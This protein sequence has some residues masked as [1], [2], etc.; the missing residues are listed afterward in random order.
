MEKFVDVILPLPL[1]A[2][3]TYSLPEDIA[4][5]VQIG[6]RV[7]VPFGR[8]K[9][10]TAIVQNIHYSAPAGYEVKEVSALLDAHPILLPEQFRFWDWLAD[11]YLCTRGDVY[12]AALPSGL[13]LESE[14]I[15]EY[16]P[17]FESDVQLP[18]KEQKILDL[19]AAE[20]EQCITKLEKESGIRNILSVIKSL[21]D[22]EAVFV[23]EELKRTYK[24][25]TETRVRLTEAAGNEHR[26]HFFFDELQR[27]A[28]KQLDLLMKYIE[29]SA[30][31]G[32]TPKEVT[33][34]ELLQRT[35]AT[36]AVFNGLV[37]RGVF[38]VYQQEI[39]R[40]NAA[41]ARTTLPLNPLNGHQQRAYCGK[42]PDKECLFAAWSHV[43]RKNGD[44][45]SSDRKSYPAREAGAVSV[46]G[47]SPDH[48]DYRKAATG[49][50]FA[51]GHLSLQVSG[52]RTGGNLAETAFGQWI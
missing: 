10:Y 37:E 24:P 15:V 34:K 48:T 19:L 31:L 33:K 4:G 5:S 47:N 43:Q 52:C 40:L 14:T 11:Y 20:P 17:D 50:R 39:G 27:R 32:K 21:L 41:A 13:K 16:N 49:V 46:A 22:K 3:F 51:S 38:E 8:K 7:V 9:Y 2:C 23:K 30:C 35:S 29:L 26:L 42:F 6:C 12:K 44:L 45:H 28:P 1:H 18:E 36:P 25:K